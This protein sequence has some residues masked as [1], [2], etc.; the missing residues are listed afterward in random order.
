MP[1]DLSDIKDNVY[2]RM[3]EAAR[4]LRVSRTTL[5]RWKKEGRLQTPERHPSLVSGMW[6]KAAALSKKPPTSTRS[7]KHEAAV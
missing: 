7:N 3:S 1:I 6:L 4:M 2:Y 5:Y